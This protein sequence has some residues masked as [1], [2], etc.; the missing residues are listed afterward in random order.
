MCV[1]FA[2][3]GDT[4]Y[5]FRHIISLT[6]TNINHCLSDYQLITPTRHMVFRMKRVLYYCHIQGRQM[7]CRSHRATASKNKHNNKI[8][9]IIKYS[10]QCPTD[11]V[12]REIIQFKNIHQILVSSI[13]PAHLVF[14]LSIFDGNRCFAQFIS[15]SMEK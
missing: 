5:Y 3:L 9:I 15:S 2:R 11:R 4:L 6:R 14:I 13:P 1:R 12:D 10:I 7:I 8:L